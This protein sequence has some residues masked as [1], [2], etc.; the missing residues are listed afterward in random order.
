VT[1]KLHI[2]AAAQDAVCVVHD[3]PDDGLAR[4]IVRKARRL[5]GKGGADICVSCINRAKRSLEA[6][7]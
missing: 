1:D 6:K 7:R 2:K 3:A 4:L 5:H